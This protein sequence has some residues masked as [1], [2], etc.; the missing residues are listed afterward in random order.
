MKSYTLNPESW[1]ES[2]RDFLLRFARQRVSDAGNAEDLVQDTFLSAWGGR[3]GFRGDCTERTWLTGILRNKIIDH[4]RRTARR[5]SILASDLEKEE[6]GTPGTPWM[7][8][9]A[10]ERMIARPEAQ[11]DR[12]EFMRDLEEAIASLPSKMGEA[13][14]MREIQGLSTEEVTAALGITKAN[15]WVLIHRARQALGDQLQQ[16]WKDVVAFGERMAA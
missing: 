16:D 9:Q 5:G 1:S 8:R 10:D 14:R 15:L 2:Y 6:E 12:M 3:S 7:E 13:F 11:A 4:Y